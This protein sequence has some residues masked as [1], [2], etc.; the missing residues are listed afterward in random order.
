MA[1]YRVKVNE[2]GMILAGSTTKTG[3]FANS[4]VVTD[5]ALSAVRDHLLIVTQKEQKPMAYAWNYPNGKTIILKLEER[6]T[7][8]LKEGNV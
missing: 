2:D 8:E 6:D 1:N 3:K 4:S 7:E 5:E